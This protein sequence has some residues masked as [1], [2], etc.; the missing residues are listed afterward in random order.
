MSSQD[1][2]DVLHQS[3]RSSFITLNHINTPLILL[4]CIHT[5]DNDHR[6]FSL[7]H[8]LV[9]Q[10]GMLSSPVGHQACQLPV[11]T[12][13]KQSISAR[14]LGQKGHT[15]LSWV[16]FPF[17]LSS[18]ARSPKM[19]HLRGGGGGRGACLCTQGSLQIDILILFCLL[20]LL[21]PMLMPP[22]HAICGH[23]TGYLYLTCILGRQCH[24]FSSDMDDPQP[25]GSAALV[26]SVYFHFCST[27]L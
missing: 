24:L 10:L 22:P 13:P 25:A 15:L 2:S 27:K 11:P 19:L 16:I 14:C 7:A 18:G 20:G 26:F 9:Q 5:A 4:V 23:H 8:Q 1:T 6:G 17:S 12:N 3:S 21:R